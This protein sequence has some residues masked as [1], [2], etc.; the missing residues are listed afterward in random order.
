MAALREEC[1]RA[2]TVETGGV[3]IGRYNDRS[4]TALVSSV[5]PAPP[6]SMSGQ[7][8]FVRGVAGLAD[9]F[10]RRWRMGQYYLGEWHFHPGGHADA[11]GED[12]MEA[13]DLA[14]SPSYQCPEIVFLIVARREDTWEAAAWIF[15]RGRDAPVCL[16]PSPQPLP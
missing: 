3:L 9:L 12:R 16:N 10:R 7:T 2:G 8:W 4:D 5:E 11:S 6:D 13:F 1:E 15:E 14:K